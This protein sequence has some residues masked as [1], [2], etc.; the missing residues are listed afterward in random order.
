MKNKTVSKTISKKF[1]A[2]QEASRHARENGLTTRAQYWRWHKQTD[3]GFLPKRPDKVYPNFSW[4]DFLHTTNSFEH[5]RLRNMDQQKVYRPFW[6]A[7]RY[8]QKMAKQF[9]L[10]TQKEWENFHD[11]YEVPQDIPK[12]PGQVYKEFV[13][14]GYKVWLGKTVRHTVVAHKENIA[15]FCLHSVDGQPS[16]VV[17]PAVHADGYS[18]I[19]DKSTIVAAYEWDVDATDSVDRVMH[20]N[21][22]QQFDGSWLIVN[23]HNLKW[24]MMDLLVIYSSPGD[25]NGTT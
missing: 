20:A 25:N 23:M 11:E 8:A 24:D 14:T 15:V 10:T 22:S 13:G 3:P 7:V 4:N 6:E 5:T 18:T 9:K 12:R 16:N 1:L 17:M 21:G 2:Y 19:A